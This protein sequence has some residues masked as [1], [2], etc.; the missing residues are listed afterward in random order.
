MLPDM[1]IIVQVFDEDASS[2]HNSQSVDAPDAPCRLLLSIMA[3][4]DNNQALVL[5]KMIEAEYLLDKPCDSCELKEG[6]C[7]NYFCLP[8]QTG[9]LCSTQ[10]QSKGS[11]HFNHEKI[12]V[13]KT[14][15]Q[16]VVREADMKQHFDT[17]LVLKYNSNNSKCCYLRTKQS[18]QNQQPA[19]TPNQSPSQRRIT[20]RGCFKTF[21]LP[22]DSASSNRDPGI[23]CSVQC[24]LSYNS[25]QGLSHRHRARKQS[26]PVRSPLE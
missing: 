1:C 5:V 16:Y 8:C 20:C 7:F 24:L 17:R 14:S 3:G 18:S 26:S 25:G 10:F 4:D 23:V 21:S 15:Y 12:Q 9:G 2:A 13:F 6:Y 11:P 19:I 22:R